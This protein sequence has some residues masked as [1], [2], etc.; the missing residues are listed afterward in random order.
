MEEFVQLCQMVHAEPL[1]CTGF[2]SKTP[3]DAAD[4]IE[5]F[6]GSAS[7]PMGA[8]RAANGHTAPYKVKY[9]QIGNELA[10]AGYDKGVP[11]FCDAMRAADPSIKILSSFP[12]PGIVSAAGDKLDYICPHDYDCADLAGVANE[13]RS[14]RALIGTRKI[15]LGITEWNTTAGDRGLARAGLWNLKNAL[16]CSRFHNIMH[17][18]ADL[19]EIANRSNLTNS[20]CSGIIQTNRY[21]LYMTPTYYAQMLYANEAG[22]RPLEISPPAAFGPGV[23]I[24]AT[25]SDD[26]STLSLFVV[27]DMLT[28]ETR[29]LVLPAGPWKPE[30]QVKILGDMQLAGEPDVTNSFSDPHRVAIKQRIVH[31]DGGKIRYQFSKFSVTMMKLVRS[32]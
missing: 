16:A 13:Y 1:I 7:S 12:T 20:F 18:N 10:G 30:V 24:S 32:R 9:W 5:Y 26:G 22:T 29:S 4:Q 28:D 6:N 15:K 8:L 23:D 21:Q 17:R 19:V 25:L 27:N 2:V 14:L 31:Q 11:A 3:K